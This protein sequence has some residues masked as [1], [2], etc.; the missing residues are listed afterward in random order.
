MENYILKDWIPYQLDFQAD[1]LLCKWLFASDK[2]FT[3]PFFHE[4]TARCRVYE[5]NQQLFKSLMP[6]S[7]LTDLNNC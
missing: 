5:E 4:T 1:E 7:V 2:T 6:D 3:E